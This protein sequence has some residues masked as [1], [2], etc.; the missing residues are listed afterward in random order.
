MLG[1][2]R[3]LFDF[4][5]LGFLVSLFALGG[6][7]FQVV[8]LRKWSSNSS[9]GHFLARK[10]IGGVDKGPGVVKLDSRHLYRTS[11]SNLKLT[12]NG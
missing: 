9:L 7:L 4:L 10:I 1:F 8:L 11:S 2:A 12:I 3:F 5:P 6:A